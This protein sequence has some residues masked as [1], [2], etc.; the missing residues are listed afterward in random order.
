[1]K[2]LWQQIF[3]YT[4]GAMVVLSLLSTIVILIYANLSSS[5]H[6]ALMILIGVEASAF[7]AVIGYF[8]GSSK[9]SSD[10]NDMINQV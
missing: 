7:T 4:L 6:D 3:Q 10:K 1:M 9:G 2:T 8:F 5:V